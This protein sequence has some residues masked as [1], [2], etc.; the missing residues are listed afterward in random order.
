MSSPMMK[1]RGSRLISSAIASRT[2]I[3]YFLIAIFMPSAG[4]A[5]QQ[6]D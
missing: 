4:S 1:T 5:P 2:A 3:A 6:A